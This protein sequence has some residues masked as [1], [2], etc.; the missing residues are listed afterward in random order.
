VKLKP[1]NIVA[2]C[3]IIVLLSR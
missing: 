1:N 3:I 2:L